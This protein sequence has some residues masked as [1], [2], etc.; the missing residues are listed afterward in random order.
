MSNLTSHLRMHHTVQFSELQA[1]SGSMKQSKS[2]ESKSVAAAAVGTPTISLVVLR[3][4]EG[5]QGLKGTQ[6]SY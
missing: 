4:T 3:K 2:R 5:A 1:L 6:I